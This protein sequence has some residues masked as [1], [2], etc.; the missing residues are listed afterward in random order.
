MKG[1]VT[2][3][4]RAGGF[5]SSSRN[6]C[7]LDAGYVGKKKTSCFASLHNIVQK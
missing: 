5:L 3:S 6:A 7:D 1:I 4:L 2:A